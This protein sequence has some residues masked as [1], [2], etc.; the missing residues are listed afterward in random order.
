[1]EFCR[2]RDFGVRFWSC[3]QVT[4]SIHEMHATRLV[5]SSFPAPHFPDAAGTRLLLKA[6]DFT[7]YSGQIRAARGGYFRRN[8]D[9]LSARLT[10]SSR[11]V[12]MNSIVRHAFK[13]PWSD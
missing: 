7:I 3:R 8:E 10:F 9:R 1:M 13:T 6:D 12:Q 2:F 5:D 4:P 11:Y